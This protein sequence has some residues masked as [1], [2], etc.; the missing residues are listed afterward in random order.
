MVIGGLLVTRRDDLPLRAYLAR[1]V[2]TKTSKPA[3]G[4]TM[5]NAG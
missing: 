1:V 4:D 2:R 5:Q 3:Q